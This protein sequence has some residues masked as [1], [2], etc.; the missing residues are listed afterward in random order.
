[1]SENPAPSST[2]SPSRGVMVFR[3]LAIVI[4]ILGFMISKQLADQSLGQASRGALLQMLCGDSGPD[5]SDCRSVVSSDWGSIPVS[6]SPNAPRI[7]TA[8]FGEAYFFAL[9]LW[10]AVIGVPTRRQWSWHLVPLAVMAAGAINSISLMYVMG[11][12]LHQWCK[13][14][15][16]VHILN[17]A[18]L[19]VTIASFPRRRTLDAPPYPRHSHAIAGVAACAAVFALTITF[20]FLL[21]FGRMMGPLQEAYNRIVRDPDFARWSYEKQEIVSLSDG[22]DALSDGPA[23]AK[24]TLVLFSDFECPACRKANGMIREW[25]VKQRGELRVVYRHYP[26]NTACNEHAQLTRHAG[27]CAAARAAEAAG[28]VG[29]AEAASSFRQKLY[30]SKDVMSAATAERLAAECGIDPAKFRE[31]MESEPAKSRIAADV[32][33]A[34]SV[35]VR[36]TPV[37]FLDGRRFDYWTEAPNWRAVLGLPPEPASEPKGK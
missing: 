1:M 35:G 37:L 34:Q 12:V 15:V 8:A 11:S 25:L 26:L 6:N 16:A 27:A 3:V 30:E 31:A 20:N 18:L 22:P 13:G 14:C 4:S 23:D 7:P 28:M 9:G 32:S 21:V 36:T 24:H 2:V 5:G 19:A 33:L 29:N 10:F 17:F